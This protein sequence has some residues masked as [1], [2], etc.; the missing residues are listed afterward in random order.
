MPRFS[1]S[2]PSRFSY[3]GARTTRRT[4]YRRFRPTLTLARPVMGGSRL[5]ANKYA[6][7][8]EIKAVDISIN[9]GFTT[10]GSVIPLNL[11]SAGSSF[12]Q[13]IGRRIE[14]KSL[15]TMLQ[16]NPTPPQASDSYP[17][18]TLRI[19]IVYDSQTNGAIPTL[20]DIIQSTNQVG[21]NFTSN[22][23]LL[24]LNNRDRFTVIRDIKLVSPGYSTD[25][26]NDVSFTGTADQINWRT[27]ID[28]YSTK[29]K[30]C[31]TQYK[32]DS[33]PA[34]IGDIATGGIFLVTL[35]F[36]AISTWNLDGTVRLRFK[37]I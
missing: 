12:F 30:G 23:G 31:L 15:Q 32:A 6:K 4:T 35:G 22:L 36:G 1:R 10:A 21:T 3:R 25:A 34:V 29:C 26:N 5:P 2:Y 14:L 18:M 28:E 17:S 9:A 7:G 37:D 8:A 19:L 13:R 27:M 16:L 11:I 20:A 33:S 24:N